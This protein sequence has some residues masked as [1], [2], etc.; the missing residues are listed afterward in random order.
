MFSIE[1]LRRNFIKILINFSLNNSSI[2]VFIIYGASPWN[3]IFGINLHF[4]RKER[5]LLPV[6]ILQRVLSVQ[7]W[8]R[9]IVMQWH[10]SSSIYATSFV[11]VAIKSYLRP[12]KGK[13][14]AKWIKIAQSSASCTTFLTKYFPHNQI[15]ENEVGEV[16]DA[17]RGLK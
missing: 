2:S 10:S 7:C 12:K 4:L 9:K 11:T 6:P 13:V 16:R 15:K 8:K 17:Y 1:G 14:I 3:S 5:C